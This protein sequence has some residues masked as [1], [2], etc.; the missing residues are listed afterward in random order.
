MNFY[1]YVVLILESR[2]VKKL[3]SFYE[4]VRRDS[5]RS[6]ERLRNKN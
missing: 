4:N 2:V 5:R 3:N 6:K 1:I